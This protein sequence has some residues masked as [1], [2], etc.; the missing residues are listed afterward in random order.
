MERPIVGFGQDEEGVPIAWLSCGHAQHIRHN[1]PF[2]NRA[3]VL[4]EEGR[5]SRLGQPLNCVRCDELELPND[6]VPYDRTDLL[7]EATLPKVQKPS[8]GYAATPLEPTPP[9][10]W[11]RLVVLDGQLRLHIPRLAVDLDLSPAQPGTLPPEVAYSVEPVGMVQFFQ[12]FYCSRQQYQAWV[13]EI[14]S[15]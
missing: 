2:V 11:A 10:I 15:N 3:W 6:F 14:L 12:E 13:R 4:T 5:A 7:T 8:G 9:G 1:P